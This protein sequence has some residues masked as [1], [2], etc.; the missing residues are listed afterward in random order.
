MKFS[1]LVRLCQIRLYD[2]TDHLYGAMLSVFHPS[3][4]ISEEDAAVICTVAKSAYPEIFSAGGTAGSVRELCEEYQ[5]FRSQFRYLYTDGCCLIIIRRFDCFE[6]AELA[7]ASGTCPGIFAVLDY[8]KKTC[9]AHRIRAYA[10]ASTSYRLLALL[11]KHG[12]I[13]ILRDR[14]FVK[15]EESFH[16][17]LFRITA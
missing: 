16:D 5:C 15:F 8:I 3:S 7:S 6:I 4:A 17:V 11:A 2:L 1:I 10:R 13:R 12:K 14:E 9:G